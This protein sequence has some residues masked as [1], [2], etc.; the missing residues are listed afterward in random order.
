M[1]LSGVVF[2]RTSA[3]LFSVCRV[4]L[5][6]P[7]FEKGDQKKKKKKSG[8]FKEF[9][10]RIFVLW[11]YHVFVKKRLSKIKYG[12]EDSISNVDL[13]LFFRQT[14]NYCCFGNSERSTVNNALIS[15]SLFSTSGEI[16]LVSC[17][18]IYKYFRPII[19]SEREKMGRPFCWLSLS[20]EKRCWNQQTWRWSLPT[21]P[22]FCD[23]C[24]RQF[25]YIYIFEHC[26]VNYNREKLSRWK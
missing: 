23:P 3:S 2:I 1:F 21:W 18:I 24:F 15:T 12:A 19:P 6:V 20:I 25:S 10:S 16:I 14:T 7:H 8:R 17:V 5:S 4:Q 26:S 11:A 22:S 13:D 9:L